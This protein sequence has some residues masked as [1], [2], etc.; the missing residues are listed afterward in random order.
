MGGPSTQLTPAFNRR[1]VYGK[2]SRYKLDEYL[3]LF[4]FPSPNHLGGEALHDQRAAAAAV[5]H[6]QRLHAAAGRAARAARRGRAGQPRAHPEG[7]SPDLRPRP[8]RDAEVKAGLEFLT[9]EPLKDIRR[10]ES[11]QGHKGRRRTA[12]GTAAGRT[13]KTVPRA[14]DRRRRATEAGDANAEAAMRQ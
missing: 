4:D 9:T 2:V 3:Q 14:A 12:E 5:P 13:P 7:L 6:E 11:G 1:T 8:Q 10:A